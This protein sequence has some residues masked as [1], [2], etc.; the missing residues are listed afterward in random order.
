MAKAAARARRARSSM[1]PH[2][3]IVAP[4]LDDGAAAQRRRARRDPRRRGDVRH[5]AAHRRSRSRARSRR[6]KTVLWN[7]PMGV[8]ETPP[9]DAGTRA[10]R[11]GDGRARRDAARRRSSAA[12]T[13]PRRSSRLGLDDEDEPRL[14]RRR[15]VARVPRGEDAARRRRARRRGDCMQAPGLR[16]QLED[17]PRADGGARVPARRFSRATRRATIARSSSFRRRS[18]LAAVRERAAATRPDIRLGV[19]N[20]HWPRRR[21]RSPART[22]RRWRATRARA[23]VL[24]G[25]SER[26]HVFGETDEQTRAEVRRGVARTG[27]TPMLCVGETL[28]EREARRDARRSCCASSAPASRCSDADAVRDDG[29]SPTSRCGRSAPVGPRRRDDASTVHAAIR[30]ALAR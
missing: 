26:R 6:A 3:A 5:R 16:R 14:H 30:A 18:S 21:A 19:Q 8:F 23:F 9:F 22:P 25:H 15:R 29:R 10:D 27:S 24:V 7:G 2:D 28:E 20:I 11:R 17:E 4:S 12:A 1:L 13:R